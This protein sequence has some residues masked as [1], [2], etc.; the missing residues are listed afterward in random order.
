MRLVTIRS[1]AD[2]EFERGDANLLGSHTFL[3]LMEIRNIGRS[4]VGGVQILPV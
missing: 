4:G 1:V 3:K 2:P